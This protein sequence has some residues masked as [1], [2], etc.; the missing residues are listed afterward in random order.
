[1]LIEWSSTRI[2]SSIK[3]RHVK[4]QLFTNTLTQPNHDYSTASKSTKL[5]KSSFSTLHIRGTGSRSRNLANNVDQ[6]FLPRKIVSMT[7]RRTRCKH[8][9]YRTS[10]D[11]KYNGNGDMMIGSISSYENVMMR[12]EMSRRS[13]VFVRY[14]HSC[15]NTMKN[16]QPIPN[17]NQVQKH[18][19]QD[20]HDHKHGNEHE[21][22]HKHSMFNHSHTHSVSDNIFVQ[23]HGGLKNPAIRITWIGLLSNLAMAIGKGVGGVMFHSQALLADAIHSLSDLVSDFL[24][25]ATISVAARPPTSDFPH[26]YGRI[27]TLGSLGVS[28]LLL[29]A[30]VS[31]GW[32]GLASIVQQVLGDNHALDVLTQFFGHGHSHTSTAADVTAVA[33]T[34]STNTTAVA[35]TPRVDLNAMWL[36]VGSIAVKEWL[37]HATMKTAIATNSNVL[38]A[39]AWHHRVDSLTSLVAVV[40]IG[41]SYFFGLSWIDSLGGLMVSILIIQAGYKN[42]YTAAL[43]LA[44]SCRTVPLDIIDANTQAVKTALNRAVS[45]KTIKVGDFNVND[46]IVMSSGPNYSTNVTLKTYPTMDVKTATMI[47]RFIE[48][49]LL[50]RDPRLK[51]ISIKCV[52]SDTLSQDQLSKK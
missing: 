39:N 47:S 48:K 24:T 49:D 50:A 21:H 10:N 27:E 44:D 31:V 30:G 32:S 3:P 23:E 51:Q 18:T 20:A 41:G 9:E 26:G 42:G 40:T 14:F 11:L 19:H 22:G 45:Q 12:N 25:L 2:V 8:F 43:E 33:T 5:T 29:L 16:E 36:A 17:E 7:I 28:A 37:F 52:D 1:M 38:V 4:F 15:N 6:F 13:N 46:V 35:E 34:A